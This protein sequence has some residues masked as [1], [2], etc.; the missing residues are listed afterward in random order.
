LHAARL[1][2]LPEI[3]WAP[4]TTLVIAQSSLGSTLAIS[5]QRFIGTV[6]GA[7]VGAIVASY[8]GPDVLVFAV[9]VFLL[10]ILCTGVRADRTAYRFGGVTLGRTMERRNAHTHEINTIQKV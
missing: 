9:G 10:G 8:F 3:Y 7:A 5:W 4:I 2:T 1:L 6:L